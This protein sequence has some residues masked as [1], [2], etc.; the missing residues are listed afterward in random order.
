MVQT[1]VQELVTGQPNPHDEVAPDGVSDRFEYLHGQAHPILKATPV[2]IC[3]GGRPQIPELRLD[4]APPVAQVG[5]VAS[6]PLDTDGGRGIGLDDH[7]DVN[8]RHDVRDL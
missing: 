1:V 6:P 7:T 8:L 5:A 2:L 3:T 4:V